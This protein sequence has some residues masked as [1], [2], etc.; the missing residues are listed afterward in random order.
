[1]VPL[2]WLVG[3]RRRVLCMVLVV[4]SMAA[5]PPLWW[6][7]QLIGLPDIGDP[8]DVAAFRSTTIPDDRNAFVLY[9]RAVAS[10]KVLKWSDASTSIPLDLDTQ[11]TTAAPEVRR[12]AELNREALDLFRRGADRPDAFDPLLT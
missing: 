7:V 6:A 11:W 9:R 8:F 10:Y 3:S 1:S 12:W 4:L 5:A 2:R